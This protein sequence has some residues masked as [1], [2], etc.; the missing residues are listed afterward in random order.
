[1]DYAKQIREYR[2]IIAQ[3][4]PKLEVKGYLLYLEELKVEEV[5]G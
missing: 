4:Y 2:E 1:L 3:L 5:D